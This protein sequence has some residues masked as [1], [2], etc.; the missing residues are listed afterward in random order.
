MEISVHSWPE[1]FSALVFVLMGFYT[2]LS[3][4]R[5]FSELS[6]VIPG[7]SSLHSMTIFYLEYQY[8]KHRKAIGST[9]LDVMTAAAT[10]SFVVTMVLLLVR[11]RSSA[12]DS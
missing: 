4:A 1:L 3:R 8:L 5:L 10:I 7:L 9:K 11:F 6:R 12:F 2:L